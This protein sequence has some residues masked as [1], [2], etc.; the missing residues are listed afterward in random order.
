MTTDKIRIHHLIERSRANGPGLR[1]ALWTQG[2]SLGCPGCF[3]PDTHS[4]R[5]GKIVSVDELGQRILAV[6]DIEGVSLLG[7]EPL[8]Q[9]RA[10]LSLLRLIK[11]GSELSVVLFTGYSLAE[12]ERM[13]EANELFGVLD[14]LIAGRYDER[15]RL[16]FPYGLRGSRNKTVTFLSGRYSEAD[17]AAVPACQVTVDLTGRVTIN[18][19]DPLVW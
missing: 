18:G 2:C 16:A 9:R 10:V 12:I 4:F 19:M 7:G 17:F 11:G 13:P 5:A 8:Q 1:A 15:L 14:V 6:P 3:N